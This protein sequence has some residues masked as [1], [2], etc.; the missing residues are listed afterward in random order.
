M[1]IKIG[2]N[3]SYSSDRYLDSRVEVESLSEIRGWDTSVKPVPPGFEVYCKETKKWYTYTT[4]LGFQ[5]RTKEITDRLNILESREVIKTATLSCTS[6]SMIA[7]ATR[8]GLDY[9][10]K[11]TIS[12]SEEHIQGSIDFVVSK[13]K[14]EFT[15]KYGQSIIG[16]V[17]VA[18]NS[19]S[20]ENYIIVT[21]SNQH[22]DAKIEVKREGTGT[23]SIIPRVVNRE[24]L[25]IQRIEEIR[26]WTNEVTGGQSG[27][28]TGSQL[29][30]LEKSIRSITFEGDRPEGPGLLTTTNLGSKNYVGIPMA[31][32]EKIGLMDSSDKAALDGLRGSTPQTRTSFVIEDQ[33]YGVGSVATFEHPET[34]NVPGVFHLSIIDTPTGK[35]TSMVILLNIHNEKRVRLLSKADS[36]GSVVTGLACFDLNGE[37]HL[38]LKIGQGISNISATVTSMTWREKW[39]FNELTDN[40]NQVNAIGDDYKYI[41]L[42]LPVNPLEP[43]VADGKSGLMTGKDKAD[44][45]RVISDLATLKTGYDKTKTD[46]TELKDGTIKGLSVYTSPVRD[47][48]E[49]KITKSDPTQPEILEIPNATYSTPGIMSREDKF[50]LDSLKDL[51][52][53]TNKALTKGSWIK[54]GSWRSPE[55]GEVIPSLPKFRL[56]VT[57]QTDTEYVS[58]GVDFELGLAKEAPRKS[59]QSTIDVSL[60]TGNKAVFDKLALIP[61]QGTNPVEL[62]LYARVNYG[63]PRSPLGPI[64]TLEIGHNVFA[65]NWITSDIFSATDSITSKDIE[66]SGKHK[67]IPWAKEV[68][69]AAL[70][71]FEKPGLLSPTEKL[72]IAYL[73]EGITED[74]YSYGVRFDTAISSPTCT[75]VGNM[76]LHKTLPVHSKMRG[77]LLLDNGEIFKYLDPSDWSGENRSGESGQVM[78]EI[79]SHYVKFS[80]SGTSREVRVSEY[81]L[82]GYTKV[83]LMY[84]SAYEA[85]MDRH[86]NKLSSVINLSERYRGGN[87]NSGT[88]GDPKRTLLGRPATSLSH[89]DLR[90]AARKRNQ[91]TTEWN[92]Y[93]YQAHKTLTWLFV[94]E[95]ATLN[96]Q[97]PFNP[98][99]THDGFRQGGLGPGVTN[100][101]VTGWQSFN[102]RQP[103]V[104]C[105]MTDIYGN[106]S[107]EVEYTVNYNGETVIGSVKIPRYRGIENPFGHIYKWADGVLVDNN[108]S[109]S[110]KLYKC[111]DPD[112]FSSD[113]VTGY[114]LAGN[115]PGTSGYVKRILGDEIFPAE[116]GGSS[117]S[118]FCDYY[119]TPTPGSIMAPIFG[120]MTES[121]SGLFSVVINKLSSEVTPNIGTRLCFLPKNQ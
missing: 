105:G 7:I 53:S 64:V 57:G 40:T 21:T 119:T 69:S 77:C 97:A 29:S 8:S 76:S 11:F 111:D 112:L 49:L 73:D 23:E 26:E 44:L 98:Q 84:V 30:S 71:T 118:Y 121:E 99:L 9:L 91:D 61:V 70:A 104:P 13:D 103:Y 14:V 116:V 94:I 41:L 27:L 59:I 48:L 109:G 54:L 117:S 83:P 34:Q 68:D 46:V 20:G 90:N 102:S 1:S 106:R 12:I 43:A 114:N 115:L 38:S 93:L 6:G 113:N 24:G 75:R 60:P 65:G 16:S 18:G 95:Y 19:Q 2:S 107:G 28:M 58:F 47:V 86:Q 101:D 3:F 55:S 52:K 78:V 63:I 32:H 120:A 66:N 33:W 74:L 92:I 88:D 25:L 10:S 4:G 108:V 5:E 81:P 35:S 62:E 85:A 56:S 50:L 45:G 80:E 87:N 67:S 79:P 39:R 42:D 89:I 15:G 100:V 22:L 110:P 51:A 17:I 31:S 82:P 96:S 72:K 36:N 37:I